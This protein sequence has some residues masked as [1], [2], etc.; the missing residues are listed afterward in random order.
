[1]ETTRTG[2]MPVA[3]GQL[4]FISPTTSPALTSRLKK[5][6]VTM[7]EAAFKPGASRTP[8]LREVTLPLLR[9]TMIADGSVA[10][11][12]TAIQPDKTFR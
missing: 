12:S 1:L 11:L 10:P 2:L 9:P 7:T 3:F 6:G 5:F 8:G 4:S